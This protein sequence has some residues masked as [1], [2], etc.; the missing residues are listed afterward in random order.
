MLQIHGEY[1]QD[2][3][4][5]Q[6]PVKVLVTVDEEDLG[7]N[8][9]FNVKPRHL[10]IWTDDEYLS[11]LQLRVLSDLLDTSSRSLHFPST[12]NPTYLPR[13]DELVRPTVDLL[14]RCSSLS[15]GVLWYDPSEEGNYTLSTSFWRY[16]KRLKAEQLAAEA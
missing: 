7:R 13:I 10:R 4:I 14:S 9:V 12:H 11:P 1:C 3:P 2:H 8:L 15:V 5:L 16:A 6:S